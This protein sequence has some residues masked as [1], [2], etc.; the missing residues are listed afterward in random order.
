MEPEHHP[1]VVLA[2]L[3]L[4]HHF[5]VVGVAEEG[6]RHAVGAQG[7]LYHVGDIPAVFLLVEVGQVLA[8]VLLVAFQVV[9]GAVGNAPQLAPAKG[10]QV[11]HVGGGLGVEGQLLRPVVSKPDVF[12]GHS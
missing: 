7:G 3:V 9:V 1:H 6:Q 10:E 8:G 11:L 12:L 5:L 4:A 2:V